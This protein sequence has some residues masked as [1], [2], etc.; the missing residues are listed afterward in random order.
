MDHNI[1]NHLLKVCK[2]LANSNRLKV[3]QIISNSK[4][5]LGVNEIAKRL[6][7]KQANVSAHLKYL[8]LNKIVKAKQDGLN[9]YYTINDSL[10]QKL[11][12]I[13]G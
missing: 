1:H 12:D 11:I 5:P 10:A 13:L 8:R 2:G 9:M 7:L 4:T 6:K 3:L